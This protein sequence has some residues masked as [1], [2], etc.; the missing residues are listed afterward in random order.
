M[1]LAPII[2][3]AYNRPRHIKRTVDALKRNRYAD[4]SDLIIY[5]D[6]PKEGESDSQIR[7]VREYLNSIS[8]FRSITITERVKNIG[9]ANSMISGVTEVVDKFD[10]V[11]VVE[12]DLDLSPD[13]IRFMNE[14]LNQYDNDERVMQISG[15]MFNLSFESETD[16]VFLPFTTSWGWATW[17]RAWD[18]FD[19]LMTGYKKLRNNKLLKNKFNLDGAYDYFKLLESQIEGKVDSWAIRWYLDVFLAG[20][21]VLYPVHSLV[22]NSG[23]GVEATHCRSSEAS[24]IYATSCAE[25]ETRRIKFP[26][27]SVN[28][29]VYQ[30]VKLVLSS[31]K[32]GMKWIK[33][34][35]SR[36][37]HKIALTFK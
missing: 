35:L 25:L 31:N 33:K 19:P 3:F 20:G 15:H 23:F 34:L 32:K 21:M 11:I 1:N 36:K 13:F 14:A 7:M 4:Q 28:E 26:A 6:G 16:A 10:K 18:C 27:V 2:V 22:K 17:K 24:G 8:G 30:K 5:S 12:D 29:E 37:F 9:L